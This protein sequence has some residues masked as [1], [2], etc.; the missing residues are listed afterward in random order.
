LQITCYNCGRN[1][2]YAR[3]CRAPPQQAGGE[4]ANSAELFDSQQYNQFYQNAGNDYAYSAESFEAQYYEPYQEQHY[5]SY[6]PD[7]NPWYIDSGATSHIASD[8]EKL[9]YPP[10]TSSYHHN[11]KTGG[12]ESHPV[13]GTGTSTLQ[14]S[15]GEIKLDHV[16]YVP[17]MKRNLMSVGSIT[18]SGH[19]VMFTNTHCWIFKE[20]QVIATGYRDNSNGLYYFRETTNEEA[21]NIEDS[22]DA[23]V[24]HRRM[25]H[26]SYSGLSF[27]SKSEHVQGIPRI[28]VNFRVCS[29]CLTGKQHRERFPKK[30]ET[31]SKLPGD[32]IHTDVIGPLQRTSLGGSRYILVFTDDF[33]RKSWTYFLKHKNETFDRFRSFK[34]KLEAETGN[35]LRYLRSDRGGEYLSYQFQAY[36]LK[37]SITRELTQARTPQQNGVA[38][39]RNRTLLERA[40][41]MAAGCNLPTYL[42]PEAISMATFLVNRSPTRTNYGIPPEASYTG[43]QLDLSNLKTFGC[44]SYVHVPDET[45][46]KLDGKTRKGLFVGYDQESKAYRIYD[47][48]TRKVMISRDVVFDE[49]KIGL[50][51]ITQPRQEDLPRFSIHTTSSIG[52]GRTQPE[53]PAEIDGGA[54]SLSH[55]VAAPS[56]SPHDLFSVAETTHSS[57][58]QATDSNEGERTSS[59]SESRPQQPDTLPNPSTVDDAPHASQRVDDNH[60]AEAPQG[61]GRYPTRTRRPS[62]KYQDFWMLSAESLE[63]PLTYT[64]AVAD[65]AW[66]DAI[67]SEVDSVLENQT[68]DVIDRPPHRK[69]ITAKWLFKTKQSGDTIKRKARIVARGFQQREGVDYQDVFA[70]VVRWSTIRTILALAAQNNWPLHQLD[71]VTAFL[72]GTLSEDVVMEIPEGFPQAG[73]PLK[74]CRI[75]RALYGLKQAPKA[76]YSRIDSWLLAQGLTRSKYDPNLYYSTKDGKRTFILLY[77]DDLL[78]TGDDHEKIA[79]LIAALKLEFRMTDLGNA[80]LYLGAE[81]QWR[82]DGILLT[83][84]AYIQKLLNKF[85]LSNCNSSLL[86]MDPSLHLQRIMDTSKVDAELYRSLV[87]SLIYVTNTRPDV[88]YAVSCVARYMTSP[89][90]AHFQA[91]KR[92]L[93]YLKGTMNHGLLFPSST[94]IAFHTFTDA[95]WGRDLDSRRSTSGILHKLGGAPIFWSSKLQP[96]VSLSST[97][98]EYRVLTDASKDVIYFR[99]LLREIGVDMTSPTPIYTDNQSSIRLVDNPVMH[100]RTKHIG[101]QQHFIRESAQNGHVQVLF[102]PTHSQEADFL[103]KPLTLTKFLSNRDKV[104]IASA[105]A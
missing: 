15:A 72:N 31:R 26:I 65:P 105:T 95:D 61:T 58:S 38:E 9:D 30:S 104:G 71:V 22:D 36:C 74:A 39:R 82:D 25:G 94:T 33:S 92:I 86:P 93:R 49:D 54:N 64:D 70:P 46:Q 75:K 55:S 14:T 85:G 45:R 29:C 5:D 12:G 44:L 16:R 51:Y 87:G 41:S 62:A 78:I 28:D 83:Q 3:D 81:I 20:E 52:E 4:Y 102:T 40:R 7:Y 17:S 79:S 67:R 27:L 19:V 43:K 68:W 63:D 24:W 2:H 56:S 103:T 37:H 60:E 80:A 100:S 99:D 66:H 6:Y 59:D 47:P 77:V 11:V 1:G 35:P 8:V 89:E 48:L 101:I 18:D 34:G 32:R 42:W 98:A 76:W 73:N 97:E 21:L 13:V 10:S 96:T 69:P 57:S 50:H 88:C 90:Q 91:A 84:A 23:A 53:I